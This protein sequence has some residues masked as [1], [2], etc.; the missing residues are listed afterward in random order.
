MKK[1]LIETSRPASR[2]YQA[3]SIALAAIM[4]LSLSGLAYADEPDTA[5]D[6]PGLEQSGDPA[7][8]VDETT[9]DL[10]TDDATDDDVSG[11]KSLEGS[12]PALEPPG[13]E[14]PA[15]DPAIDPAIE[16]TS[17]EVTF[18]GAVAYPYQ[19]DYDQQPNSTTVTVSLPDI[20]QILT[21]G[22]ADEV[23]ITATM[24][25]KGVVKRE[26][27]VSQGLAALS[28][29]NDHFD[30]DFAD[31]GK[32]TVTSVFKKAG[33][34]AVIG[35][36]VQVGISAD[37]YNIAPV[38][39]T[40]PV[41]F[42]AVSMFGSD[43]IRYDSNHNLI[44]T[45]LLL[46]R[47]NSLDWDHLPE[48]VRGLPFLSIADLTYQP[49][50]FADA[51][52]RF[53]AQAPI[54]ADYVADLFEL[55]P[56][57][58]FNLYLVDFYLGQIQSNIYA[59]HIP[60][61]QYTINVLSDG[62]FSYNQFNSVYGGSDPSM[63]HSLLVINWN[64]AKSAAYASGQVSNGFTLNQCINYIF[65]A[66]NSEAN[67]TWWMTTPN[68]L[69]SGDGNTFANAVRANPQ[70]V[71][72]N[73]N[74]RLTALSTSEQA[75]LKNLFNMGSSYFADAQSSGKDIMV[76]L[77]TTYPNE[78]NLAYGLYTDYASFTM[79]FYGD[80]YIYYYKGH[81]STP[82]GMNPQKQS[83][84]NAL[85]I[86]DVDSSIPAELIL[87][88]YPSLYLS[89]YASSTYASVP[90]GMGK[91]MFNMT[92]ASGLGNS[93]YANMDAWISLVDGSK[94]A[95]VIALCTTGHRSYLVEYSDPF[96]ASISNDYTHAIW[97]ATA[98]V[99]SYY[100]LT[101]GSYVFVRSE[102]SNLLLAG[103]GLYTISPKI[104]PS[105]A[106]DVSG[107][108]LERG[109]NIWAWT[110]NYSPAQTFQFSSLGIGFYTIQNVASG[111]MM[112]VES[113][114]QQS[115]TNVWQYTSNGTDAQRWRVIDTGDGD[116]SVYLVSAC[117]GLYL[118]MKYAYTDAGTN[119]WVYAGNGTD[120]Q[121]FF[122]HP[123]THNVPDGN[124][125][126]VTTVSAANPLKVLDI[127]NGSVDTYAN[128]QIYEDNGTGAQ[129][130]RVTYNPLNGYYTIINVQSDLAVDVDGA[131]A[132]SGTNVWQYPVNGTRAQMWRF[133]E[134][135]DGS[136][137]IVS[138]TGNGCCLDVFGAKPDNWTNVWIYAPNNTSAQKWLLSPQP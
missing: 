96:I 42:M 82:T 2:V 12:D 86:I 130:F 13:S 18:A 53:R 126:L 77:G 38:S 31:Y 105:L 59:N 23:V 131:K 21:L 125:K 28:A 68:N 114:G 41:V 16:P 48:G 87:F 117:N 104:A 78:T 36:T 7:T 100:R 11:D 83:D 76:F 106:I 127:A 44:P 58:K 91:L 101:A 135:A 75:E 102:N 25:Y 52:D 45:I 74:N 19:V 26:V 94:S 34:V 92:K 65:A 62:A 73:I 124:Y 15:I 121:K 98:G 3:L 61:G 116:G 80:D 89:G 118:D 66:V 33:A 111:M 115:G 70:I 129:R 81:P 79:T 93:Q 50:A 20:A 4:V 71:T 54:M 95:A 49:P 47:P 138:G 27:V 112:D 46:E 64:N 56:S 110:N 97:D 133:I 63:T 24:S 134:N 29:S 128:V 103:D 99:V 69:A 9:D 8:E 119:I 1:P 32:F 30:M 57:A 137:T 37:E 14:G 17:S 55:N 51:S 132:A 113:A 108:S 90:V 22:A 123:V 40:L 6:E 136:Y 5:A 10:A 109:A 85:G 122:L 43:S 107:G 67:A 35:D 88:Y 120:A 84:L 60:A 72:F 39:A